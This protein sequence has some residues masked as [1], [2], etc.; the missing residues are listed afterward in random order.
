MH[1]KPGII[2]IIKNYV[3]VG[4][5][6][7]SRL[8]NMSKHTS[9]VYSELHVVMV[10]SISWNHRV[11]IKFEVWSFTVILKLILIGNSMYRILY[12]LR[13]QLELCN[14][15]MHSGFFC[16]FTAKF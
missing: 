12:L 16:K 4:C 2:M 3:D 7:W 6:L 5:I 10:N 14:S 8:T 11:H 15:F 1:S 13:N 9:H